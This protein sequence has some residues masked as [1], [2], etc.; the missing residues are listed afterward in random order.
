MGSPSPK[1]LI[2]Q[3]RERIVQARRAARA[4]NPGTKNFGVP[5]IARHGGAGKQGHGV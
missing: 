2:K 4:K 1:W 3:K 5:R